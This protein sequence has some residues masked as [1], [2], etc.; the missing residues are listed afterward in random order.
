MAFPDKG[1]VSDDYWLHARPHVMHI[2]YSSS[3]APVQL[4]VTISLPN[5]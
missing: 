1:Y 3:A 4:F 5:V 2:N